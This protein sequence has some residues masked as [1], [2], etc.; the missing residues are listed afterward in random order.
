METSKVKGAQANIALPKEK[1]VIFD[2]GRRKV[3]S[4]ISQNPDI[5]CLSR[6]ILKNID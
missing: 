1:M 2:N 3:L 4:V 6:I 5:F